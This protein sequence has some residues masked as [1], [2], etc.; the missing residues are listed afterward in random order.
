M[1]SSSGTTPRVVRRNFPKLQLKRHNYRPR[2]LDC[3]LMDFEGRCAYSMQYLHSGGAR[4]IQ[5][6]H[7]D[8][9]LKKELIQDYEN[10]FLASAHCNGAKSD[11]WPT[12]QQRQ[13]G[14]RFLNCCKECDYGSVIFE[15]AETHL[16]VGSTPAARYHIEILDLNAPHLIAERSERSR[17]RN[18]IEKE[19]VI[20]K[21]NSDAEQFIPKLLGELHACLEKMIPP[22]PPP[23][24]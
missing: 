4:S 6:D 8:P 17:L 5:I 24:Q 23:P 18:L 10:L 21:T 1:S 3:L 11:T 15:N 7:H 9:R 20:A 16:L 12:V 2:A 14:I 22:I 13:K 19:P